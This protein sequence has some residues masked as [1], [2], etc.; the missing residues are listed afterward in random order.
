M[1]NICFGSSICLVVCRQ[2]NR[3]ELALSSELV[4]VLAGITKTGNAKPLILSRNVWAG[5]A[6]HGTALWSS[7]IECS[8]KEF[9]AQVIVG[10][11]AGLSGIPYWSSD[12]SV[13][14]HGLA[15]F[16]KQM[17]LCFMFTLVTRCVFADRS[18][19]LAARRHPK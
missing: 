6:A 8:W 13:V 19:G 14:I 18:V 12:V 2:S 16:L 3:F 9:R 4:W 1:C 15:W 7:D 5:A 17:A 11:S 10:L